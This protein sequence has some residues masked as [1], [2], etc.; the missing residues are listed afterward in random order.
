MILYSM[1]VTLQLSKSPKEKRF[2]EVEIAI[3]H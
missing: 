1:E 3:M 2:K